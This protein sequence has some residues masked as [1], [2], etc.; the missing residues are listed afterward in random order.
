MRGRPTGGRAQEAQGT[1]QETARRCA[2]LMW[3]DDDASQALGMQLVSVG[4]GRAVL[5]MKV[6]PDMANGHGIA[7]G[8]FM[9]TLA[10]S[11]FAFAC[12]SHNR[13]TVAQGCD[14]AFLAPVR[15]GVMLEAE[16][17]E[18]WR[19]GRNGIY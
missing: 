3:A 9:F 8:G 4:P 14:I 16:A 17:V 18:R 1:A 15:A 5:S 10:D 12:N 2:E 19:Q 6:R 13:R 7:H 11:A